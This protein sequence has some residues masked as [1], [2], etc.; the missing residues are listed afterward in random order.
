MWKL[1]N[2]AV[3][4]FWEKLKFVGPICVLTDYTEGNALTFH[5]YV[6][7]DIFTKIKISFFYHFRLIAKITLTRIFHNYTGMKA[8][9]S[10]N[11]N[12]SYA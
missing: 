1:Q 9:E 12:Y 4:I 8:N 2:H 3:Y 11:E 7:I 10:K 5:T 6:N